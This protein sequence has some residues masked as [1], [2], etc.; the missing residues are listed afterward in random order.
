MSMAVCTSC[1]G[2]FDGNG[3]KCPECKAKQPGKTTL[4][5]YNTARWQRLRTQKKKLNPLCEICKTKGRVVPVAVVDHIIE[6]ADGGAP[7]D[8][9]NLQ[10]LCNKHHSIKTARARLNRDGKKY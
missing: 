9:R 10:S 4:G 2:K 3:T 8:M 1:H 5:I 7:F 6:I